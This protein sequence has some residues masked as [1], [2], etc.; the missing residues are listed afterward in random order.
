MNCIKDTPM[1]KSNLPVNYLN[2]TFLKADPPIL[3]ENNSAL[4]VQ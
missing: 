1:T 4:L 3:A 2:Q